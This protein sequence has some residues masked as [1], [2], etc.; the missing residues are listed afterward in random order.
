MRCVSRHI[1][2]HIKQP[3]FLC[4]YLRHKKTYP[5]RFPWHE[6]LKACLHQRR[7]FRRRINVDRSAYGTGISIIRHIYIK[8]PSIWIFF[9]EQLLLNTDR[10]SIG[11][12]YFYITMINHCSIL[13]NVIFGSFVKE[14]V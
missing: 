14:L 12:V 13:D 8:S 5:A 9:I 10:N 2:R 6:I 1:D 4:L 11:A 7:E 3:H